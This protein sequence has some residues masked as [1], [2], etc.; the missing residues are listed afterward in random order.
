MKLNK[1]EREA[2]VKYRLERANKTLAEAVSNA[3]NSCWHA[4][5]NRLYYACFYAVCALLIKNEHTTRT[6]QGVFSKLGEHF[7]STGLISIEQ[8]KF[9]RRVLELRQTGDYDDFVEFSEN[10]ILPLIEPAEQFIK[11]IENIINDAN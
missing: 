9:Y 4:A 8:N 1:T 2:V 5:A 10:E 7:V 6:H 11:T 3:E